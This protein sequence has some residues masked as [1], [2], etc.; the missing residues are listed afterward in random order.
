M[1][2]SDYL[3]ELEL[4]VLLALGRVGD[5]AYGMNV[6]DEIVAVTGREITAPT[7]YV[8]LSRLEKKGYVRSRLGRPTP[9]R[10]GR[11][12]RFFEVT[13]GGRD[14]LERSREMLDRLWGTASPLKPSTER[15]A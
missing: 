10:G 8:T 11:A 2:R 6:Y 5:D 14:A 13:P 15:S 7:V 4:V 12:K 3:G 9:E 1:N